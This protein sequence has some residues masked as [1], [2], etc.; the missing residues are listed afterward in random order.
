MVKVDY[1]A[2]SGYVLII[3]NYPWAI[4]LQRSEKNVFA[5]TL[6]FTTREDINLTTSDMLKALTETAQR[7]FS[8]NDCFFCIIRS[9]WTEHGICGTDD[10]PIDI[11]TITSLFG[12]DKCPSLNGKPKIFV[13][14]DS[15]YSFPSD[16]SHVRGQDFID[17]QLKSKS[18][19]GLQQNLDI[20][21]K[22]FLVWNLL[23]RPRQ[24]GFVKDWP[25]LLS[26]GMPLGDVI[27]RTS[28]TIT[29]EKVVSTLTKNV[30]FKSKKKK[31]IPLA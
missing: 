20:S 27:E 31:I 5:Q 21:E 17:L 24:G 29:R 10:K 18:A 7:D 2:K 13:L 28:L 26:L 1:I 3:N 11:K 16:V 23:D 8:N 9:T 30:Y 15:N 25:E 6:G 4:Q 22:D 14:G 12:S 19:K